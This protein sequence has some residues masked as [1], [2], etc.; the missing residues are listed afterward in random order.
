[1]TG[2]LTDR[3]EQ[4]LRGRAATHERSR[5]MD[6]L[7]TSGEWMTSAG[8]YLPMLLNTERLNTQPVYVNFY[9]H[10]CYAELSI[11]NENS[12]C[13]SGHQ[14]ESSG[15]A[16]RLAINRLWVQFPPG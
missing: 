8:R 12:V 7:H 5:S 1:M 14:T 4:D 13:P 11:D 16:A 10:D 2:P 3:N 9:L 15:V 6:Y